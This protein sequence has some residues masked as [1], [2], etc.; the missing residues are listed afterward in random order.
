MQ[1]ITQDTSL[2][3]SHH[4]TDL[5]EGC[6]LNPL[7]WA[8]AYNQDP[9]NKNPVLHHISD[10]RSAQQYTW[11]TQHAVDPW[12]RR[13]RSYDPRASEVPLSV[14]SER[15]KAAKVKGA[16]GQNI[17]PDHLDADLDEHDQTEAEKLLK[18]TE[19][20]IRIAC[21]N[22]LT[23]Y[24]GGHPLMKNWSESELPM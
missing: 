23:D 19:A 20:G 4:A 17:V 5:P 14:A 10:R 24:K 2:A 6:G 13:K 15:G 18:K 11:Q 3:S 1:H 12:R 22:I 9:T 16:I 7:R 21:Q 8:L